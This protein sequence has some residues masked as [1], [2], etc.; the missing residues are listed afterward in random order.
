MPIDKVC[1]S[2]CDHDAIALVPY[3]RWDLEAPYGPNNQMRTRFGAF[4][5]GI[6]KFDGTY[7]GIT[8]PDRVNGSSTTVIA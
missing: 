1:G 5:E 8:S 4:L 7:F 2:N 6:D 3:V